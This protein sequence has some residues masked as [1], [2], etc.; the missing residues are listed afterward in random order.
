MVCSQK[1]VWGVTNLVPQFLTILGTVME[2]RY[3][4]NQIFIVVTVTKVTEVP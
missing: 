1:Q 3:F 4:L 2:L